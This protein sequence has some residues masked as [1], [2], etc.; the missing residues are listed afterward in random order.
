MMQYLNFQN[1]KQNN[2]ISKMIDFISQE[3]LL[4]R[5]MWSRFV[6]VF[7]DKA[8]NE[9]GYWRG[10]Y[11]GK[12]MRGGCLVYQFNKSE[13]LYEVLKEAVIKLLKTQD[14]LGRFSTYEVDNEFKSWDIWCR[15]YVLTGLL[16][17]Y[18]ICHEE[19]LKK[20]VLNACMRHVDYLISKIGNKPG[21]IRITD[22]SEWWL[23]VNSSSILE[24]IIDLYKKSK[25]AR[26]FD[27]ASYIVSEGGIRDGSL[28]E[29]VKNGIHRPVEYPEQ[30]AYE[31]MSFFEG[32]FEYAKLTN[33]D[34]LM[35]ISLRFFEDVNKYEISIIGNAG[36]NEE[37]FSDTVINQ[38]TKETRFM[39][40]TCV[41]VTWMRILAKLYF[42][43]G[44][45]KYY[46]R[47]IKAGLNSFYGSINFNKEKGWAY[48]AKKDVEPLPF[49]SYSPLYL[50]R[51]G[52]STGGH[53]FFKDGTSYGCCACIGAASAGLLANLNYA[54]DENNIYINEYFNSE[55][56]GKD[57]EIKIS[58]DYFSLGE[59][60][61]EYKS[62]K[63]IKIRIPQWSK[64]TLIKIDNE[65]H[66]YK[67]TGYISLGK[68]GKAIIKFDLH[69][70]VL[71][72]EEYVALTYGD[73]TLG[74]DSESNPN[75]DLKEL[76]Y[77]QI[78]DLKLCETK[79]GDFVTLIGNFNNQKVIIKDYA[80][81][82]KH[83]EDHS[84][85]LTA[86]IK[87]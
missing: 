63:P 81:C 25:E 65:E 72:L 36:T 30:K 6:S 52:I 64:K 77:S 66:V 80:S 29:E 10:E 50:N 86:W 15:K 74:I 20:V 43:T 4:N 3:Q 16:H 42:H 8:D 35:K 54:E 83:W 44:D 71:H 17:F 34:E 13:E 9:D 70:E 28:I 73:I 2:Q 84:L 11:W 57:F 48:F 75:I 22:T 82:G 68:V 32:I 51:R 47:F 58:G 49:D 19:D 76:S 5:E 69:I 55:V 39:Q 37:C 59:V 56:K 1:I 60:E 14:E 78:R 53:N 62:N 21:Q 41:V 38:L 40:E 45:I 85:I 7:T 79:L 18:D 26:Y 61:I 33:N 24:A 87:K 27:F 23:G 67:E 46:E 31:T 12:C